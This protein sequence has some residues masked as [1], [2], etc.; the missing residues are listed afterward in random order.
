MFFKFYFSQ[1]Q[2]LL[3][4]AFT[5]SKTAKQSATAFLT[6]GLIF[7]SFSKMKNK[8]GKCH[9]NYNQYLKATQIVHLFSVNFKRK[10]GNERTLL[11]LLC[12]RQL[13]KLPHFLLTNNTISWV[14][15]YL[16]QRQI[17]WVLERLT[18]SVSWKS[19]EPPF[20]MQIWWQRPMPP[21]LT[22]CTASTIPKGNTGLSG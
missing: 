21:P 20:K 2:D 3:D 19:E 13:Y 15:L 4:F 12:A 7:L 22:V 5:G 16:F 8:Q 11:T 18:C 6:H 10:K 17:N 1:N 9:S 14:L